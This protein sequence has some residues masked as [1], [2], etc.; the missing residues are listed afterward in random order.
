MCACVRWQGICESLNR[1]LVSNVR[2]ALR[3]DESGAAAAE[4]TPQCSAARS[5]QRARRRRNSSPRPQDASPPWHLCAP[6]CRSC[7]LGLYEVPGLCCVCPGEEAGLRRDAAA[8][9]ASVFCTRLK[10]S[11]QPLLGSGLAA[12]LPTHIRNSG[13][14]CIHNGP[15]QAQGRRRWSAVRQRKNAPLSRRVISHASSSLHDD[16]AC[17]LS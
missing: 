3:R 15:N 14:S 17:E 10:I 11:A 6:A 2:M 12:P 16:Y 7:C 8:G 13:I 4:Q 5:T 1:V 9:R